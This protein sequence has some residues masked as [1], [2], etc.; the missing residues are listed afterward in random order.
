MSHAF[1]TVKEAAELLHVAP[2]T[3]R[4]W[5]ERG[6]LSHIRIGRLLRIS[7]EEIEEIAQEPENHPY[8]GKSPEERAA[9]A[10]KLIT[11]LRTLQ[12]YLYTKYGVMED[13][14]KILNEMRDARMTQLQ[15]PARRESDEE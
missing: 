9:Y 8:I 3:I 10:E 12:G 6:K 4:R 14:V 1:L 11:D 15:S 13:S 7:K 5:A 2:G